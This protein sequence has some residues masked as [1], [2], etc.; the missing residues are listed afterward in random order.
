MKK[1]GVVLQYEIM[2][3][4]KNKSYV[5]STV[6]IA[7]I[8]AAIMFVPRFFDIS[9]ITG[10]DKGTEENTENNADDKSDNTDEDKDIMLIYDESGALSDIRMLQAAFDDMKVEKEVSE[11]A[12]KDKI[13][14]E[15]AKKG[16]I[17]HSLT[18]YEYIVYNKSMTDSTNMQFEQVLT[19]LNQ[20][21]YCSTNNLDYEEIMT[22][23]NPQINSET[24]VLGKDMGANYMYCYILIIIIFMI[25]IF[26][27]VMVATSVTQEKSNRT[28][29]VLV[30]SADTK[31]LFFGKVLAGT[32]AALCQAGV[33]MLAVVGAYKINQ[34]VWG[35][36]L[37][38]LLDIPA[39]VIVTYAL[40]GLGGVLF[41]T[42]IY[43]AFG[44]LVSKTEDL[45]KSVGSIQMVI[46]VVYFVTL[47]QLGNIDGTAMKVLSY[48]PFSSYS[49]MFARVAMGN[50]AVWEI[51]VSFIIL[52]GGII[53]VGI[54]GSAI[55][56][57]G[58]LRY[59]NPIKITTAIKSLCKK[60]NK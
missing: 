20:M 4:L 35:G 2:T 57:M 54:A 24:V 18:D 30:T 41:Y 5:I 51:V 6:I 3:Y 12:L 50:V 44:A 28:I 58:T 37:D 46:M 39:G 1:L 13:S 49:A 23:F 33:L 60:K 19:A 53:A 25:I 26:Y 48:L 15:E 8:A 22:A 59:G 56:R 47:L 34:S 17:V 31:I 27:G 21:V 43:G 10:V 32:I 7:V 16:F 40:F 55:Y 38:M 36:I 45:N 9:S 42:F 29:E 52:V 11:A 14:R